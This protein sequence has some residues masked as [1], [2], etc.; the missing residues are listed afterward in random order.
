MP[1]IELQ[2]QSTSAT[3]SVGDHLEVALPAVPSTGATWR[4]SSHQS[5]SVHVE[6]RDTQQSN[7]APGSQIVQ[8]F[9]IMADAPGEYVLIFV[10]GRSWESA[11]RQ[12]CELLM[13]VERRKR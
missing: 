2:E 9:D 7:A 4:L 11:I 3:L 13:C 1:R 12:R 8:V 10:Y 6:R 5:A